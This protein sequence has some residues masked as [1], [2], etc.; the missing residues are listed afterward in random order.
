M[1]LWLVFSLVLIIAPASFALGAEDYF[2]KGYQRQ[3]SRDYREAIAQ[4]TKAIEADRDYY[5]AYTN[6]ALAY[7]SLRQYGKAVVDLT[8]AIALR[9][10]R[11]QY[12]Y[13]RARCYLKMDDTRRALEDLD[14]AIFAQPGFTDPYYVRAQVLERL[15]KTSAAL[16]DYRKFVHLARQGS[17]ESNKTLLPR[18]QEKIKVLT[19]DRPLDKSE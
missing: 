11:A 13:F 10:D 18:V 6:R 3:K 7:S 12:Y 9:P 14:K 2:N 19:S 15:G 1:R 8:R 4:Y 17:T 16:E 5:K